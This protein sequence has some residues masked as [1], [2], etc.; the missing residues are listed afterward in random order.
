MGLETSELNGC[1]RSMTFFFPKSGNLEIAYKRLIKHDAF[2]IEQ[3]RWLCWAF[4]T[5]D[6]P[7]C[8]SLS[9]DRTPAEVLQSGDRGVGSHCSPG[10]EPMGFAP[11]GCP[12]GC[13]VVP[14]G[15]RWA[16]CMEYQLRVRKR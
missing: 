10:A 1:R 11:C 16:P 15:T 9:R 4:K 14:V 6:L 7:V 3:L 13:G 12:W 8:L 5:C 2:I